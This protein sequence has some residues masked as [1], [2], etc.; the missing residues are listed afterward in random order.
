MTEITIKIRYDSI[1]KDQRESFEK[2]LETAI[3]NFWSLESDDRIYEA[4][5]IETTIEL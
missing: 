5:D 1:P 2:L 4:S 3:C